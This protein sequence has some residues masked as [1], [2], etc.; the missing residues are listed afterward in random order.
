MLNNSLI[1]HCTH[2][3]TVFHDTALHKSINNI[4]II[5]LSNVSIY[6]TGEPRL[7]TNSCQSSD[8]DPIYQT[9]RVNIVRAA[10]YHNTFHWATSDYSMP[11]FF[12]ISISCG[13][14]CL[15][16]RSKPTSLG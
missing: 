4:L 3:H 15:A 11:Y 8:L 13:P 9:A 5:N 2:I 14:Y 1:S 7:L 6:I 10:L 16:I 12:N